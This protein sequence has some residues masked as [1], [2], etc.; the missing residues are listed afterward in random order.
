MNGKSVYRTKLTEVRTFPLGK[1]ACHFMLDRT[2][3]RKS[4]DLTSVVE[5]D[6]EL[7]FWFGTNRLVN[8]SK[9]VARAFSTTSLICFN[10]TTRR[11]PHRLHG[12]D[13]Y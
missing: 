13:G 1:S 5:R 2:T 6:G 11:V 10:R 3:V 9:T 7:A 8:A 12:K 4:G